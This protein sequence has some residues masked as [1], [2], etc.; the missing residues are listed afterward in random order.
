MD[1]IILAAG[2]NE[3]L[4]G[5]VAPYHKPLL[6]VNGKPLILSNFLSCTKVAAKVIVVTAPQNTLPICNILNEWNEFHSKGQIIVQPEARGPGDALYRGLI[7]SN[8]NQCLVVCAD[9]VIPHEDMELV[10]FSAEAVPG[11]IVVGIHK[12][13]DPR[14]AMRF[15]RIDVKHNRFIEGEPGG[16]FCGEY[17]CWLGPM[18]VPREPTM[19]MFA[20]V[21]NNHS[22]DVKI[23]QHLNG[24]NRKIRTVDVN[25]IDIGVPEALN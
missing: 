12:T 10:T 18:V 2:R 13:K 7:M 23:S 8:E 16:E 21:L 3:R 11:D 19:N 5:L 15:T 1:A 22:G 14:E 24:L 9:N 25:C 6:V 20:N 4:K 17:A